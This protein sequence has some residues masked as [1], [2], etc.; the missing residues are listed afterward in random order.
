MLENQQRLCGGVPALGV[1][2]IRM[3]PNTLQV[4]YALL[5][6]YKF[7]ERGTTVETADSY[8]WIHPTTLYDYI[9][10]SSFHWQT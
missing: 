6:R 9:C 2:N 3:E 7:P 4:N 5:T 10:I 8:C 1:R